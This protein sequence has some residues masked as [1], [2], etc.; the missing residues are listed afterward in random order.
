[1]RYMEK[2]REALASGPVQGFG[3][4][5]ETRNGKVRGYITPAFVFAD[6]G[7]V[8]D[9]CPD[10]CALQGAGCYAQE[11]NVNIH[12][13]NARGRS[14]DP[15]AWGLT[16]PK[17]SL[18][19]WRVSGDV[20]GA[21]GPALRA[22]ISRLHTLRPDLVGWVYTHAW[23][24]LDV[25]AWALSTPPGVV[26]VASL[27]DPR[28][29]AQAVALGYGH[30]A[31]GIETADGKTFT[32]DEARMARV[33]FDGLACPAQR[34]EVGCADCRACMRAPKRAR[35]VRIIFAIHGQGHK[36]ARAALLHRRSRALP[37][38]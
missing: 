2:R 30:V 33:L 13:N 34:L 5:G 14:Y 6:Y 8:G 27:D 25:A 38:A 21:D 19:R 22:A 15:V 11:A 32:D 24:W 23:A 9:S 28:D 20:V 1:M 3:T 36:R 7:A 18:I 10:S 37:L 17:G 29:E 4:V 16:L 35:T 12:Q 31:F 26:V